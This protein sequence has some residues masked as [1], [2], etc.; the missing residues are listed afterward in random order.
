MQWRLK[1][2]IRVPDPVLV[3]AD[4]LGETFTVRVDHMIFAITFP[5]LPDPVPDGY[6]ELVCPVSISDPTAEVFGGAT[7]KWGR[8]VFER[9]ADGTRPLASLVWMVATEVTVDDRNAREATSARQAGDNFDRLWRDALA[10]LEV[11]TPQHL[12]PDR[13]SPP[14]SRGRVVATSASGQESVTDWGYRDTLRSYSSHHAVT[15][16]MIRSA[17][18][19]S[20][21]DEQLPLEWKLLTRATRMRDR[22]LALLNVAAAAEVTLS[23][24]IDRELGHLSPGAKE[25]IVNAANGTAGLAQLAH[26]LL[27]ALSGPSQRRLVDRVARP[28]N[29]AAHQGIAPTVEVLTDAVNTVGELLAV[30]SPMPEVS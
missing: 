12:L 21:R 13:N 16:A 23:G 1:G 9:G 8:S 14:T 25:R 11:W 29:L 19:R 6:F 27:P 20:A 15:R 7:G 30:Y 3:G 2:I 10:W 22:R 26:A 18:E 17:L 5:A 28:R 24:A 4:A